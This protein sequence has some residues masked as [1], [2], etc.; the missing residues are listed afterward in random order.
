[1]VK[2]FGLLLVM[3]FSSVPMSASSESIVWPLLN[4]GAAFGSLRLLMHFV[5]PTCGLIYYGYMR[6]AIQGM[7]IPRVV[8]DTGC[9][10]ASIDE[11]LKNGARKD[12]K[13]SFTPLLNAGCLVGSAYFLR[14]W[15]IN[16]GQEILNNP[17]PVI[18]RLQMLLSAIRL[19]NYYRK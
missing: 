14:F 3:A 13:N 17:C 2:V 15:Y 10:I 12:N 6:D 18:D 7:N 11:L 16:R 9:A 4:I 19:Y 5:P 1:M 8:L